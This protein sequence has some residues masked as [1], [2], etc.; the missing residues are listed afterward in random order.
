[1]NYSVSWATVRS[2]TSL[3]GFGISISKPTRSA[4]RDNSFMKPMRVASM[5]LAAYLLNS[6]LRAG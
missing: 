6:A 5:A 1:M 2:I 4:T 3:L